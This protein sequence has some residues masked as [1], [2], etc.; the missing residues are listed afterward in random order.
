MK[1]ALKVIASLIF[2]AVFVYGA[3]S[4]FYEFRHLNLNTTL[5]F[6][7]GL[8]ICAP[9]GFCCGISQ[10]SSKKNSK[11]QIALVSVIAFVASAVIMTGLCYL[12]YNIILGESDAIRAAKY[13]LIIMFTA[14]VRIFI[15][16]LARTVKPKVIK[17]VICVILAVATLG[18]NFYFIWPYI[19]IKYKLPF[20]RPEI[21]GVQTECENIKYTFARSTE[22]IKPSDTLDTLTDIDICLAENEREG[23]QI[24]VISTEREESV[25]LSVTDFKNENGNTIPV[26]L[27]KEHYAM[28]IIRLMKCGTFTPMPL[29]L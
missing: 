24:A 14:L 25:S 28:C 9:F 8:L 12:I 3:Y 5:L 18:V 17:S 6:L 29:F 21:G 1:K 15:S 26:E 2:M 13:L 23:F 27:F 4:W 10:S 19:N 7:N 22:K 11:K 16:L 20:F